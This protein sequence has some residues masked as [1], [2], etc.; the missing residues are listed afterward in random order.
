MLSISATCKIYM[1]LFVPENIFLFKA[2]VIMKV[3]RSQVLPLVRTRFDLNSNTALENMQ[4][5][6]ILFWLT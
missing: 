3:L 5:I 4:H 1:E 6:E 2:Q